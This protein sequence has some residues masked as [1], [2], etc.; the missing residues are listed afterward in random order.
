MKKNYIVD[1]NVLLTDAE[2][3]TH[4]YNHQENK[5]YVP[6]SVILELDYLKKKP[7]TFTSAKNAIDS[8]LENKSIIKILDNSDYAKLNL[9]DIRVDNLIIDEIKKLKKEL[10]DDVILVTNDNLLRLE[11]ELIHNINC[12]QY[13]R[14][15]P[16][17]SA[18]E[19]Y[20]GFIDE[21]DIDKSDDAYNFFKI[22]DSI[23][24]ERQDSDSDSRVE[25]INQLFFYPDNA[26][27]P[28]LIDYQYNIWKV[29]ARSTSQN[30]AF[31][32]LTNQDIDI[33]S[34]Q[35]PAGLGKSTL[36]LSSALYLTFQKKKYEKIYITKPT[37]EIGK[38]LGFLPGDINEKLAPYIK[39]LKM[40]VEKLHKL[41]PANKIFK[42]GNAKEFNDEYFEV[43]PLNFIRGMT[44]ENAVLIIDEAQNITRMEMRS[45]LTR[46]GENVKAIVIGDT[47]QVDN[48]A[49]TSENNGLNW[50]V[51]KMRGN[52]RYAHVTLSG[53]YSRGLI[54]DAVLAS[55]L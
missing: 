35:S 41:R 7:K 12:E 5:V 26:S 43:L 29:S 18:S 50:L 38:E 13:K 40:I 55:G 46:C 3:V 8:L 19:Q 27:I 4:L 53:R 15:V 34:I 25:T 37:I 51:K 24:D 49:N 48:P 17:K 28:T 33:V 54:T 45:L 30:A 11:C 42:S 14:S 52:P 10:N 20:T 22:A 2:S 1:T 39:Y 16:F 21:T 31:H 47:N 44:I 23:N 32:L 6:Y 9:S 36:T